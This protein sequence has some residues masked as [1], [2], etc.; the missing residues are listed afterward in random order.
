MSR[1]TCATEEDLFD[2]M[3]DEMIG[4]EDYPENDKE[5]PG[6]RQEE[7]TTTT[8]KEEYQTMQKIA[9]RAVNKG[10]SGDFQTMCM[11]L[12]CVHETSPLRL[13]ELLEADP[14]EFGHDISGIMRCLNR[15]TR[16]LE[17]FF[18]PRFTQ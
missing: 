4:D 8:T 14:L 6:D 10:L 2:D 13:T 1:N 11:D 5:T 17:D 16:E 12:E 3:C 18:L 9:A 15:E 7:R